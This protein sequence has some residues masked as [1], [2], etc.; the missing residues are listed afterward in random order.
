MVRVVHR[1]AEAELHGT[2]SHRHRRQ[3]AL[4]TLNRMCTTEEL[5]QLARIASDG[6]IETVEREA[7]RRWASG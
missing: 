3:E 4:T 5:E 1:P 6:E 7:A 2:A